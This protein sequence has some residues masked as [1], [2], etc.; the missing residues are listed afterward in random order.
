MPIEHKNECQQPTKCSYV[1]GFKIVV[2]KIHKNL[3][4]NQNVIKLHL[5]FVSTHFPSMGSLSCDLRWWQFGLAGR[6]LFFPIFSSDC[7]NQFV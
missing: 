2:S 5:A 4:D 6:Y 1:T 7:I 3:K